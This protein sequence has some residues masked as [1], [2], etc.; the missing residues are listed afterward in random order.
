MEISS[1]L[2]PPLVSVKTKLEK[3]QAGLKVWSRNSFGNIAKQIAS[4]QKNL[5]DAETKAVQ[6]SMG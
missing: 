5:K 3:I 1:G 4:V 2:L 6:G